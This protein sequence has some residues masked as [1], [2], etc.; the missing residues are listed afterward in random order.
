MSLLSFDNIGIKNGPFLVI[1]IIEKFVKDI[2][3]CKNEH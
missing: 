1:E 2:E 3:C